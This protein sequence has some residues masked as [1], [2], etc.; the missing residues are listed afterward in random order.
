M[1]I[2][3]KLTFGPNENNA[4]SLIHWASADKTPS[5]R[6]R[7]IDAKKDVILPSLCFE[8][9]LVASTSQIAG[10]R[11]QL[12]CSAALYRGGLQCHCRFWAPRPGQLWA[13]HCM[14]VA[15]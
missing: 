12:G 13:G 1:T 9:V 14:T 11:T 8:I 15:R 6:R 7:Q 3:A 2:A 5:A 4:V 10:G